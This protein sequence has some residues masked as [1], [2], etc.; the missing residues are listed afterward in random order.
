MKKILS[1]LSFSIFLKLNTATIL[2]DIVVHIRGMT[3]MWL[4]VHFT[5]V[6]I[7]EYQSI[8]ALWCVMNPWQLVGADWK[9]QQLWAGLPRNLVQ[10]LMSQGGSVVQWLELLPHSKRALAVPA[11]VAS[12]YSSLDGTTNGWIIITIWSSFNCLLALCPLWFISKYNYKTPDTSASA[13]LC[14]AYKHTN[15]FNW[16]RCTLHSMSMLAWW[17]PTF[18]LKELSVEL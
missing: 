13:A 12:V 14:V 8:H 3:C 16:T 10:M 7:R 6:L 11:C 15:R 1:L 17:V 4:N 18:S 2:W 9:T 5:I